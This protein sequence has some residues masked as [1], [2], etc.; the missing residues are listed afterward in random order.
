VARGFHLGWNDRPRGKME[1]SFSFRVAVNGLLSQ[2]ALLRVSQDPAR[3]GG[4]LRAEK[5][6][7]Q[8]QILD[9]ETGVGLMGRQRG[10]CRESALRRTDFG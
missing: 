1:G 2:R 8:R 9:M 3:D 6:L 5:L 7:R 10:S 4:F